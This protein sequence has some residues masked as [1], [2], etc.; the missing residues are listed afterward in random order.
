[1]P[2]TVTKPLILDSDLRIMPC[3]QDSI[4]GPNKAFRRYL[5]PPFPAPEHRHR[6]HARQGKMPR[7]QPDR[8]RWITRIWADN[9]ASFGYFLAAS[10]TGRLR[11]ILK[12][13]G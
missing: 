12:G 4:D 3:R 13:R 1:M 11:Q 6:G 2:W 5:A 10:F 7:A 9:S 8:R